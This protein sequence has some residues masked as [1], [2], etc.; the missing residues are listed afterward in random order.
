MIQYIIKELGVKNLKPISVYKMADSGNVGQ[1]QAAALENA[2]KKVLPNLKTEIV[3]EA[4]YAFKVQSAKDSI[5]RADF[6]LIF[7]EDASK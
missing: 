2:F 4:M 1:V 5:N 3:Q 7:H 6:E